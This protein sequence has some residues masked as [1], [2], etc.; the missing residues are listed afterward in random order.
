MMLATGACMTIALFLW[1]C[2]GDDEP[3]P[4]PASPLEPGSEPG[5]APLLNLSTTQYRNTFTEL[6]PP[7]GLGSRESE[8]QP[9]LDSGPGAPTETSSGVGA[10]ISPGHGTA[11]F[12]VARTVGDA[13][14]ADAGLREA[15]AGTCA[16]EP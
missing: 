13:V 11:F 4:G 2:H 1:A 9:L 15:L 7:S 12:N 16:T 14:E 3:Q 5:V 8:G 6:A 10:R